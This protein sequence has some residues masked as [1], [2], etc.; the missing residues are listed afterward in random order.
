MV[1]A[2]SVNS[3]SSEVETYI[4]IVADINPIPLSPNSTGT[5]EVMRL[6]R[7]PIRGIRNTWNSPDSG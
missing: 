3:E 2:T 1:A 4:T 5:P 6:P 7:T